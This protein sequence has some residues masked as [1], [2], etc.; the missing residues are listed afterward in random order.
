MSKTILA[1]LFSALVA[2]AFPLG[3]AADSGHGHEEGG[4]EGSHAEHGAHAEKPEG[5]AGTWSALVAARDAI[6]SDVEKG[7]LAEIHA[8][9]EPLPKLAAFVLEE[10][11]DLDAAKRARVEGA[12]KQ[13]ARVADALHEAADRGDAAQTRK[14]LSKLDGLLALVR[15]Q[16]PPGALE[17]SGHGHQGHSM[18]PAHA[19]GAHAHAE[20]PAGVVD[21][22]PLETVRIEAVDPFGFAPTKLEVRAGVPT[23][24]ELVNKGA[25]EHSLVVKTPDGTRDWV[26]LHVAPGATDGATYRLDQAGTYRVLCTVPGHTEGGMVGELIVLAGNGAH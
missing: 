4:A 26:H 18:A 21:A 17:A 11:K 14:E 23:R 13:V 12:V 6:A 7:A 1:S 3:A 19:H 5:L 22:P 24:I 9:A 16:Y 10:S 25:A 2:L 20:R 8:K 15:A